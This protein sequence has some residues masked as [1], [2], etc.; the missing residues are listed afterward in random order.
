MPQNTGIYNLL[1]DLKIEASS[2]SVANAKKYADANTC[3]KAVEAYANAK[4]MKLQMAYNS[5]GMIQK[6]VKEQEDVE[7][8]VMALF[9]SN[10]RKERHI[11]AQLNSMSTHKAAYDELFATWS[12]Q[13][14]IDG[15]NAVHDQLLADLGMDGRTTELDE[16]TRQVNPAM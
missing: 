11:Q 15:V 13:A 1:A 8:A 7:R 6:A 9:K 3:R 12:G 5:L 2:E 16:A 14:W 10:Q 4:A